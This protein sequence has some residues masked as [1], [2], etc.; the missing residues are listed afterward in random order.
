MATSPGSARQA[1]EVDWDRCVPLG[2]RTYLLTACVIEAAA[3]AL[4]DD[5]FAL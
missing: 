5:V 3:L 2:K 4:G 1:E